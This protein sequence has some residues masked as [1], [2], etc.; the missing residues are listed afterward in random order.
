[1]ADNPR[2]EVRPSTADDAEA[3]LD[4][5]AEVAAEGLWIGTEVPFDR[6]ARRARFLDHLGSPATG[7]FVAATG[8]GLVGSLGAVMRAG[9]SEGVADIGMCVT[10][11]WRGQGVGSALMEACLGW[12]RQAGAHKLALTVW[13]HNH[14]ARAL[15][16]K[17]GFVT[18]GTLR[19][20][21]RRRNGELWDAIV[22]GLVLDAR[23]PGRAGSPPAD[24]PSSP[25]A[26]PEPAGATGT[27]PRLELPGGALEL[28]GALLRPGRLADAEALAAAIDD[29][30]VHRWL[31]VLPDPYTVEDARSFLAGARQGWVEG[32]GAHFLIFKEEGEPLAGGVGLR[33]DARNPGLGEVGYWLAAG[34]RGQGLATK[35][36][37]AVARWALGSAGLR[38]LQLLAALDN[39]ASR[40]VAERAGFAP[41]GLLCSWRAVHGRPTDF[42]LY[43]R[44]ARA[45][46][47]T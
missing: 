21:V 1:M 17:F 42:A 2:V 29:P 7:S 22:M 10:A 16:A 37:E 4:L 35:A 38:R 23:S 45:E 40:A 24:S 25:P 19:R 36:V 6:E 41:E 12:A 34:A 5:L 33:L 11:G 44:V 46:T 28:D 31:D 18:E 20:E 9:M 3:W 26:G 27:P 47:P 43:A 8:Y 32:T 13:P 15:Y 39:R 30:E 14:A